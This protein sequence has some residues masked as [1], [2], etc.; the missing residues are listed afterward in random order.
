MH[1][2]PNDKH[3]PPRDNQD[4][5]KA[6]VDQQASMA[7]SYR[8]TMNGLLMALGESLVII[9]SLLLGG[10]IRYIWKGD[11]MIASWMV[12]LVAAWIFGSSLMKLLPGWGLGPIEELRRTSLLLIGVFTG[13]TAMLFWGKAAHETSRF[14][15]TFGLLFSLVS[16]PFVRTQIKRL[17]IKVGVWGIPT[18]ILTDRHAGPQVINSIRQEPGLGYM[19]IGVIMDDEGYQK[20]SEL[21][22]MPVIGQLSK[23]DAEGVA[24]AAIIALPDLSNHI[25]AELV[26]NC[27]S[28]YRRVVVIPDIADMPSLWVKPR[29]LVGMLGLEIPSNLADPVSRLVKRS[30][31]LTFVLL[32]MPLWLP[33]FL[34][35]C[36]MI[37]AEDGG[38]PLFLQ[39]RIG[40]RQKT[41]KT[42]KFRTMHPNAEDILQNKL[43]EDDLLRAEWEEN[44]KLR[45]DPRI[46][47][48]GAFLRRTSL[49]EI[50]QFVNVLL[51]EMSLVG[52][53]PLPRYHYEEQP[54]RARE[55]RERVRPGMTG[56]WQVSGRS[57]A[58][59]TG[60]PKWDTYYVR[61]WSIWLDVIIFARTIRTVLS[62]KGAY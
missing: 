60:M 14:T 55:L 29:D 52:P 16:V 39:E 56:L 15:L 18:V 50:P 34:I 36:L 38:N 19:P 59:H 62:G 40:A 26:E 35:L 27:L 24:H 2:L 12:Y 8:L 7:Y 13:T 17:L 22:G 30:F 45:N 32:T 46:T 48:V 42:W 11:P 21:A 31:D 54:N 4:P 53:R 51:G 6:I 3:E 33:L 41:F 44:F 23:D 57:E 49:D 10:F 1:L 20:G 58:G 9:I 28:H 5:V 25:T 61:N 47:K 37:W 43:R